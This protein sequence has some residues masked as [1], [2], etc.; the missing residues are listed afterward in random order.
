[1]FEVQE[2]SMR[3]NVS[4]CNMNAIAQLTLLAK[5]IVSNNEK[6]NKLNQ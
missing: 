1:M 3:K 5:E 4:C 2:D 6:L